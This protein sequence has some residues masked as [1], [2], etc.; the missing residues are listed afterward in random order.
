[1]S[2]GVVRIAMM[3]VLILGVSCSASKQNGFSYRPE[4]AGPD[5]S[6]AVEA[7]GTNEN[8]NTPTSRLLQ[9]QPD[10]LNQPMDQQAIVADLVSIVDQHITSSASI[11]KVDARKAVTEI[12][13]AYAEKNNIQLTPRQVRKLD[14]YAAKLEKKQQK[15]SDVEWG[16]KNNLEIFLLAAAGVGLVVGFFSAIGWFVFL[17]AALVYL[18]LK[19]LKD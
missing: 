19:L 7:T 13:E 6:G 2:S 4:Y 3:A 5:V 18:Y 9:G 1:M 15:M 11:E 14:K 8:L 12:S 10:A 16:P 17:V